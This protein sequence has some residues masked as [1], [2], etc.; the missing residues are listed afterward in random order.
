MEA[1]WPL[2][3]NLGS[4]T[5]SLPGLYLGYELLR[6]AQIQREEIE[7]IP[8]GRNKHQRSGSHVLKLEET[9]Q[10]HC[11]P[12][13]HWTLWKSTL[14]LKVPWDMEVCAFWIW[15]WELMVR[16]SRGQ[17]NGSRH[18]G[19]FRCKRGNVSGGA[20]SAKQ[21]QSVTCCRP[22]GVIL[23]PGF[24]PFSGQHFLGRHGGGK[25][26]YDRSRNLLPKCFSLA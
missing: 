7:T 3:P 4:H 20:C 17:V 8:S 24:A 6:P 19:G 10:Q 2:W 11:P 21:R 12:A 1:F 25:G 9:T 5:T 26:S 13:F 22:G 16:N 23:P 18:L 14:W 15:E